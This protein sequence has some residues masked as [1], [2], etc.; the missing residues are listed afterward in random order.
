MLDAE[1]DIVLPLLVVMKTR[2]LARQLIVKMHV[3]RV[4]TSRIICK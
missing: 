2:G 3:L 1:Y 4:V